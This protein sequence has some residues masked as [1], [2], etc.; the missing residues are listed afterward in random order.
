VVRHKTRT[1]ATAHPVD[2]DRHRQ[3]QDRL[4]ENPHTHEE[5]RPDTPGHTQTNTHTQNHCRDTPQQAPALGLGRW[6][7]GGAGGTVRAAPQEYVELRARQTKTPTVP[8]SMWARKNK[9]KEK[10]R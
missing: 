3:T 1:Q 2:T 5:R 4:Q 7:G 6:G 9:K 8:P 10:N